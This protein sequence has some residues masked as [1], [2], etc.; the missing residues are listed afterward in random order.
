MSQPPKP[1]ALSREDFPSQADW[2]DRLLRPI[3]SF[4][5]QTSA[6]LGGDLVAQGRVF[7]AEDTFT[8]AATV[9]DSFPRYFAVPGAP[10]T[11]KIG[12][13]ED[14]AAGGIF[15]DAVF[16]TW[17]P[18]NDGKQFKVRVNYLSGLA[19][20]TKYRVTYEVLL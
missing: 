17:I 9:S 12:G 20:L 11:V 4:I 13:I 7:V 15:T 18:S 19:A 6:F 8:T 5:T 16:P 10:K 1:Q 2:I 14:V 3:N